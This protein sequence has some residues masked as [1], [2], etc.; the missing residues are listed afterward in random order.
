[1]LLTGFEEQ[2]C[3]FRKR[4]NLTSCIWGSLVPIMQQQCPEFNSIQTT[5]HVIE[6]PDIL[7]LSKKGPHGMVTDTVVKMS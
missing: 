1:M 6:D 7:K 4:K 3:H 2:E 5:F